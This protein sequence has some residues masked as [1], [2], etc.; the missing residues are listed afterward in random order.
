MV[1]QQVVNRQDPPAVVETERGLAHGQAG[2]EHTLADEHAVLLQEIRSRE[3]AVRTGLG[4][5]RWPDREIRAL[6]DYLRYEL[7]DQAAT[8]ERLLFPL[9]EGG[10]VDRRIHELIDDHV[11]LRDVADQLASAAAVDAHH[12]D[13]AELSESLDALEEF[14]DHH[15]RSEQAVLAATTDAGVESLR[16][17]FRCHSWFPVTDGTLFDLDALPKEYAHRAALE[18]F[19]RLRP[20]EHVQVRSRACLE[21]LWSALTRRLPGEFGWVYLEEGPDQWKAEV[22]RR[23]P[24]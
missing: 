1:R 5:G 3:R 17:P 19:F 22:T 6:V 20:G 21:S 13:P 9:T 8:E 10:L 11:Y 24:R 12:A 23:S 4:A 2:E 7:L 16:R 14:L 18:R 15:M